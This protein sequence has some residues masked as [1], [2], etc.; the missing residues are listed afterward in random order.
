MIYTQ[1]DS[2]KKSIL[3]ELETFYGEK[4]DTSFIFSQS[5]MEKIMEVS[6]KL[7]KEISVCI[8][9]KGNIKA[10][11][12]GE[13]T[14]VEIPLIKEDGKLSKIRLIHT[15][16][17]GDFRLSNVDI[18]ALISLKL[19]AICSIALVE[20]EIFGSIAYL[21]YTDNQLNPEIENK[22]SVD[23]LMNFPLWEKLKACHKNIEDLVEDSTD[24]AILVSLENDESLLELIELS[25]SCDIL[26]VRTVTQKRDKIDSSY[27][28]G[29][30]KA[31][32]ISFCRQI[33]NANLI[34]FD[35]ELTGAMVRNLEDLIGARVIDRTTLILE[36]FARRA[37]SSEAKAQVELAQLKYRLPRLQG[38]GES[39]S[40]SGGGIGAKG[41]GEKK[42]E[43]DKRQIKERIYDLKEELIKITKNREVQRKKRSSM[44][45]ISLIGY[46]NAGKSTLRNKMCEKYADDLFKDKGEVFA[47]DMLFATLDTTTR[48]I[49]INDYQDGALTDTVGFISKLPHDLVE[50]FKSTLEEAVESDLLIHVIDGKSTNIKEHIESVYKVLEELKIGD[51]KIIE[52]VNKIDA[53]SEDEEKSLEKLLE[54][55]DYIKISSKNDINLDVLMKKIGEI[56]SV[57]EIKATFIIPYNKQGL[58]SYLHD[59]G[60]IISTEY[61]DEGTK[62]IA[63]VEERIY[64]KLKEY[65]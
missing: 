31:E 40:R 49:K 7:N 55:R 47:K 19:D 58:I 42:L 35:D 4:I 54:G 14:N 32:E 64:N 45:K 63:I 1:I 15:H 43:I 23:E 34:I 25:K 56:L 10:I 26:P 20:G 38:L 22:L 16:P 11:S 2:I 39:L 46:T 60:K 8:D 41:P 3:E 37:K 62:V 18:S 57:N 29:K 44:P 48:V 5:I 65:V 9:R 6:M 21:N 28:I 53:L 61:I 13:S 27:Y 33:D 59:N 50:S 12:I 24:R 30:G 36:I 17:N 51:K 52:V